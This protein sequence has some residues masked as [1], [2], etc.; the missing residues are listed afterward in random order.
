MA[1]TSL[2]G[3]R[4]AKKLALINERKNAI[5]GDVYGSCMA[6]GLRAPVSRFPL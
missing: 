4:I 1:K 5:K 2:V 6:T 3:D